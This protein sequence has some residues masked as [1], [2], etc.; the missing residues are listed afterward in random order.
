MKYDYD[1]YDYGIKNSD[2]SLKG[3]PEDLVKDIKKSIVESKIRYLLKEL[4]YKL[5]PG[6]N[7]YHPT[8]S[9]DEGGFSWKKEFHLPYYISGYHSVE[10]LR[11]LESERKKLKK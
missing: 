9:F 3:L 2:I 1:S 7:N 8:V 10:I 6:D 5:Y 11:F 4:G